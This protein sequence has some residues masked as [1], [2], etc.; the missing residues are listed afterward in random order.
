MASPLRGL[1]RAVPLAALALSL[2]YA[3]LTPAKA[4]DDGQGSFFSSVWGMIGGGI[5][6]APRSDPAIDYHE[7]APLVL[8]P[9]MDLPPPAATAAKHES[10]LH[11]TID[12]AANDLTSPFAGVVSGSSSQWVIRGVKTLLALLVYGFGFGFL[13]RVLRVKV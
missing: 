7:R 10:T 8:P 13:A 9:K 6:V 2:G 11:K 12:D 3:T 1:P 4:A 5:G